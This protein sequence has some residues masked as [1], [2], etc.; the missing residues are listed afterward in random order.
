M[1]YHC[2]AKD[3]GTI[4]DVSFQNCFISNK[5][6]IGNIMAKILLL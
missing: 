6:N 5:H 2:I 1:R 3:K 4:L